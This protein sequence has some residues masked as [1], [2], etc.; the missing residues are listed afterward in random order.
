MKDIIIKKEFVKREIIIWSVSFLVA[1]ALNVYA[2]IKFNS[3]WSELITQIHI[4]FLISIIIYLISWLLRICYLGI[5]YIIFAF[6]KRNNGK[7]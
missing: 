5:R 3:S 7:E 2:I 4:V 6:K 1:F